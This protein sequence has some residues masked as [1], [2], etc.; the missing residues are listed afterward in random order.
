M[1]DNKN[2]RRPIAIKP[3]PEKLVASEIESR[4]RE[5]WEKRGVYKWNSSAS[6][7]ETFVVDTPPPTVSGSLHLGHVFSYTQTDLIVRFKRMLGKNIFYP[8]GW[9][10]NGLPTERRVQ[11]SFGIQCEVTVPYKTGWTPKRVTEEESKAKGKAAAASAEQVSRQNFIE[12]C[13]LLTQED[14]KIYENLWRRIGLSVD[15]G[16]QYATIDDHCR[17]TSQLSFLDLVKK[18]LVYSSESPTMWDVDF[19]TAVAQAEV[20]DR[21]STGHFYDIE[22]SVDGSDKKFTI[23]TTRPELLAACIAVVAHPED[24]RY[25]PFFGEYAVTPLFHVRVPILPALH[26]DPEKGTGI[27]MVCTFGDIMDVEWWK[28]SDAPIRQVIGRD[29]KMMPIE[30]VAVD[31]KS[32]S[33]F[34]SLNPACANEMYAKISG[35]HT[36][37]AKKVVA[38]LLALSEVNAL[39][40]SPRETKQAVKFYE[41]GDRPLEFIPTRQWYI[42]ILEHK[43]ELLEQGKKIN[44]HPAYMRTRYEHWVLGL[45]QDWCISRQRY[46]GVPFPVWYPIKDNGVV[47]YDHPLFA[48]EAHLPIDPMIAVPNGYREEQ[49]NIPGGFTADKDVMD[50]WATSSVS[51]QIATHWKT[52]PT[53]HEKLFP[54]DLRPQSHEI[55]RTWAF[56]TIV[57]AY[58]HEQKIPWENVAISGWILD[59]DRKKMSKSKGKVVTPESFIDNYSSDAVRYWAAKARLGV[60]TAFDENL[61]KIGQKV[62]T[63][64]FNAARFVLGI[65][66]TAND[67]HP[68]TIEDLSSKNISEPI[69]IAWPLLLNQTIEEAT[70]YLTRFDYAGALQIIE[71]RFWSF[72]DHYLELVKMRAYQYQEGQSAETKR[73]A[74]SALASLDY[75]LKTFLKLFAPYFP[76]ITDEIWSWTYHDR[77]NVHS[78]HIS[79]WPIPLELSKEHQ[80]S[81]QVEFA[82]QIIHLAVETIGAIRAAKTEQQKNMRWPVEKLTIACTSDR[83]RLIELVLPDVCNAGNVKRESVHFQCEEDSELKELR[84]EV[85]LA[86]SE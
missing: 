26:A 4:W 61:F 3:F 23:S 74:L 65:V 80:G 55:I 25:K 17:K 34:Q 72:C 49:R 79:S 78:V 1:Q 54:T 29:G 77:E 10:D 27:L 47:D 9:D 31:A 36:K 20:E 67:T 16:L 43:D 62:I 11:N 68:L 45:N 40:A 56:Y 41:K 35:Q 70:Q 83:W 6:R 48:E 73:A 42:K 22:F 18:S 52:N 46:F 14:E 12:A 37:V 66:K 8:M 81:L 64:L 53:R 5:L 60:D 13:H 24:E 50:T 59:P 21:E 82:K 38:E 30:F 39:K 76:F 32:L 69:D 71:E 86:I 28:N 75:T 58:Y 51:P 44:W 85:K 63:K 19:Q 33:S 15:W 84:V 7:A 2:T 57:K